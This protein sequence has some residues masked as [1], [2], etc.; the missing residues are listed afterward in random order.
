MD[1]SKGGAAR[2]QCFELPS[3]DLPYQTLRSVLTVWDHCEDLS[4][5]LL[6]TLKQ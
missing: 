2:M 5:D 6:V 4:T 1:Y 3:H